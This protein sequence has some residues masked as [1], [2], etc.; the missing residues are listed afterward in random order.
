MTVVVAPLSVVDHW[1]KEFEKYA[2]TVKTLRYIGEKEEREELRGKLK[3]RDPSVDFNV[4]IT[5]PEL[6][7]AD[8][9]FLQ[10]YKWRYGIIDEAHRLKNPY[11]PPVLTL[12]LSWRALLTWFPCGS[13]GKPF[14]YHAP[15]VP[16]NQQTADDWHAAAEQP[17]V[18]H[19]LCAAQLVGLRLFG[20]RAQRVV[21]SLHL[22]GRE[23]W[24][25][26]HFVAPNTFNDL[27]LFERWFKGIDWM[28]L[29]KGAVRVSRD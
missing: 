5:T 28:R 12:P 7:R 24:A 2:S 10:R 15:R 1:Q 9:E 14:I 25:L 23:L 18:R 13:Q 19:Q 8:S 3:K 29:K 20:V 11:L 4:L 26:L 6:L 27:D 21:D 16:H 17:Q 22:F